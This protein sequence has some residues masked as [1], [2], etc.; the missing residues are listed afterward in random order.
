MMR[1]SP[2]LSSCSSASISS[3][4]RTRVL[5]AVAV[6]DPR[7]VQVVRGELDPYAVAGQ[8][9]DPEPSHLARDVAENDPVH[10]VELDTEHRVGQ[11]LYDLSLEL[12]F[13]FFGHRRAYAS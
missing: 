8:D 7:A 4:S 2:L 9:A 1:G 5:S 6:D 10:V 3:S 11:G 13:F 12:D